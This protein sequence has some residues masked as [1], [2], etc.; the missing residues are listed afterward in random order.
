MKPLYE[1]VKG[2]HKKTQ[3]N[4]TSDMQTAFNAAKC[5]LSASATLAH[6]LPN[7]TIALTTDAS[8]IS[9]GA[10]LEQHHRVDTPTPLA[11]LARSKYVFVRVGPQHPSLQ[12]PYQGPFKVIQTGNKTFKVLMNKGP[13]TISVDRLKPAKVSP[14]TQTQAGRIVNEPDRWHY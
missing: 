1:A 5:S 4:W 13:Q 10:C 9:I 3:L 8:D 2:T 12:R 7:S 6:P 14:Q 11:T